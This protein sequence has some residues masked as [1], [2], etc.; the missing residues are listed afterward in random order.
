MYT[1]Q[2]LK[3]V[4]RL[5]PS[6]WMFLR[7]VR[8][9]TAF[10]DYAVPAG[11]V[12]MA[13]A[14][15][16]HRDPRSFAHHYRFDPA[17]WTPE[18][19]ASVPEGVYFP[20]SQGARACAGEAFAKLQDAL[21]LA[22][23][24]QHWRARLVPGQHFRPIVY[25]SNAP[26]PGVEMTLEWRGTSDA[27]R[28]RRAAATRGHACTAKARRSLPRCA[29]PRGSALKN[30]VVLRTMATRR[31]V[32]EVACVGATA[33]RSTPERV[34]NQGRIAELADSRRIAGR[35]ASGI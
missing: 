23:L 27:R 14:E 7:F 30:A 2:V 29:Q 17:R 32:S 26:R 3:E 12:V 1:D 5:F 33:E 20:F 24:G 10:G 11:S 6:V 15:L 22:T 8:E 21:I 13:C 16:M 4:R 19:S 25:K 34:A 9:D 28:T 35:P 18:A 31:D